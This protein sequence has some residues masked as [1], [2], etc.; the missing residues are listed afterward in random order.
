MRVGS[1]V[2]RI[3]AAQL[4]RRNAETLGLR[5]TVWMTASGFR[6]TS[7]MNPSACVRQGDEST[8]IPVDLSSKPPT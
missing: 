7:G 5:F 3:L 4:D 1:A 2:Y 8:E 6:P